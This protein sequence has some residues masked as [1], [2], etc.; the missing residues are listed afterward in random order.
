MWQVVAVKILQ[1]S[2]SAA[3]IILIVLTIR[4]LTINRLPKRLLL[5]YGILFLPFAYS[6]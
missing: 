1:T 4:L 2:L 5:S 6:L 3:L